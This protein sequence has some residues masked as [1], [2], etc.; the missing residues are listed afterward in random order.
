MDEEDKRT[1]IRVTISLAEEIWNIARSQ[2]KA[3]GFNDN[4]SQYVRDL[5]WRDK[6][7]SENRVLA[8]RETSPAYGR[9]LK[10]G[11][12]SKGNQRKIVAAVQRDLAKAAP[13][14]APKAK[15]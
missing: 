10:A 2:M 4:I 13:A 6:E 8:L 12:A 5:I 14:G 7:E 15:R 9:R 1:D 3:K 11:P